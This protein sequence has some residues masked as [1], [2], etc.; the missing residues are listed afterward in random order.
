MYHP[1]P[2]PSQA[3]RQCH[4]KKLL[5]DGQWVSWF[6]ENGP[7]HSCPTYAGHCGLGHLFRNMFV[8]NEA[9]C[10][11]GGGLHV[12]VDISV[13]QQRPGESQRKGATKAPGSLDNIV[14]GD[15]EG[16]N[17]VVGD[18]TGFFG[19]IGAPTA[20]LRI[21][22]GQAAVGDRS[23]A[24]TSGVGERPSLVFKPE[25][26][27][28]PLFLKDVLVQPA[29]W[30]GNGYF[31]RLEFFVFVDSTTS[32][33]AGRN[34][35][36]T[37]STRDP[38][39]G[40]PLG[41]AGGG[42]AKFRHKFQVPHSGGWQKVVLDVH[43]D[44]A[45]GRSPPPG[46]QDYGVITNPLGTLTSKG[47]SYYDVVDQMEIHFEG[48]STVEAATWKI[49]GVRLYREDYLENEENVHSMTGSVVL[50]PSGV[51]GPELF[52]SWTRNKD[53]L[54]A[55]EV[56]YAYA[57]IHETGFNSANVLPEVP[58][59]A[60]P[61]MQV[62][63]TSGLQSPPPA[64]TH[65]YLAVRPKGAVAFKQIKIPIRTESNPQSTVLVPPPLVLTR[66][67]E[68]DTSYKIRL[69]LFIAGMVLLGCSLVGAVAF[70]ARY[71]KKEPEDEVKKEPEPSTR[72]TYDP[73]GTYDPTYSYDT[74]YTGRSYSEPTYDPS[75]YTEG[76]V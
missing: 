25:A 1:T 15:F 35:V 73:S 46:K 60:D 72:G 14:L 65:L 48:A 37:T 69:G 20:S 16:Q 3:P 36:V 51:L 44:E 62:A 52:A 61:T 59:T 10:V 33:S 28:T 24:V 43:A 4:D 54:S 6:D 40:L 22:S 49:D 9:C 56:R 41:G 13:P 30:P 19:V 31:N 70:V 29:S 58:S 8:A 68:D 23:L 47:H 17:A 74:S 53:D 34:L 75:Y 11:C 71:Q 7:E 38:D 67:N 57:N 55:H 66:Q 12:F 2:T 42:G 21:V 39:S 63:M 64:A 18:T 26:N 45:L 76:T 27:G 32:P 5:R 50:N